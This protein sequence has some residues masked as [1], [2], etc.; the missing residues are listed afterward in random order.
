MPNPDRQ[1]LDLSRRFDILIS[2]PGLGEA[3]AFAI[4]ADMPDWVHSK[5]NKLQAWQILPPST[6]NPASGRTRASSRAAGKALYMPALVATRFNR[7]LKA[8]YESLR[9]GGNP[10][11]SP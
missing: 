3:T 11:K 8:K 4:V 10:Q 9:A 7:P 5:T 1:Q 6:A 2:I